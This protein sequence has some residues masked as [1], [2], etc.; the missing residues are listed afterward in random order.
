[1]ALR[2]ELLR[3][4][5]DLNQPASRRGLGMFGTHLAN[6]DAHIRFADRSRSAPAKPTGRADQRFDIHETARF[7]IEK[8]RSLTRVNRNR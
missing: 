7:A 6:R 1:M 4:T 3:I 5:S 8:T 2:S